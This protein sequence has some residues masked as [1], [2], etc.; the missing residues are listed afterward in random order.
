[1]RHHLSYNN[2]SHGHRRNHS[3]AT[4][5][6]EGHLALGRFT[7]L[8]CVPTRAALQGDAPSPLFGEAEPKVSR[9]QGPRPRPPSGEAAEVGT[10][11]EGSLPCS[12]WCLGEKRDGV[13]VTLLSEGSERTLSP[14]TA[15]PSL[16]PPHITN[17]TGQ[18]DRR[19]GSQGGWLPGM[20]S[21]EPVQTAPSPDQP[22]S[23][24][25][26]GRLHRVPRGKERLRLACRGLE[27]E[28]LHRR[29]EPQ[30]GP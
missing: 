21:A 29:P 19:A 24:W 3:A 6:P 27:G 20:T 26:R 15:R 23:P 14:Q 17:R 13:T 30:Q 2:N 5:V 28:E 25:P 1:M 16:S 8:A 9:G 22:H 12:L 10:D 11:P 4:G 18:R 7:R